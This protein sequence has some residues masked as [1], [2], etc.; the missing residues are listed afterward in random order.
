MGNGGPIQRVHLFVIGKVVSPGVCQAR[1]ASGR[2]DTEPGS[3][4]RW[5]LGS[6][7]GHEGI[8]VP[9]GGSSP[10]LVGAPVEMRR[11]PYYCP[12]SP[13]SG[14]TTMPILY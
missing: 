6:Q 8:Q 2:A 5:I 11:Q 13:K 4:G 7:G 10:A 9:T 12:Y 1:A 14:S 3:V